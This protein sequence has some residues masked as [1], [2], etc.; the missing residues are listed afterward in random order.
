MRSGVLIGAA[1]SLLVAAATRC[2]QGDG[3]AK[4]PSARIASLIRQLGHDEFQAREAAGRDLK[5][6]GE[7]ALVSLREAL[8]S[9]DPEIRHRAARL[10]AAIERDRPFFNGRD[11][12][13]WRGLGG[14]WSVKDG[15]LVGTSD[16]AMEYNT[17][18]CSRRSYRDF[19][20]RFQVRV[21]AHG[22][23][24]NSGVQIRSE[25]V[26]PQKFILRGPQC[27]IGAGYWGDLHGE[28]CGGVIKKADPRVVARVV[29]EGAYHDYFIRCAG[30]RVTIKIN[31]RTTLDDE[32]ADLPAEGLI[33]WQLHGGG[34]QT[35]AFRKIEFKEL[36][37][38]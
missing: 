8:E 5:A 22:W 1:V 23:A 30:K 34:P 33:G 16:G 2:V 15:A 11:L 27:D 14:C 31:G 12:A 25:L 9:A 3:S 19:E 32:F 36:G 13:G 4:A 26:H 6:I 21:T 24:G 29:T 7:P 38:K 17:C 10:V 20:L 35:I 37:R 28:L 18:L